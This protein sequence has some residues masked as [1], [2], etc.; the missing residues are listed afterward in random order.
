MGVYGHV[1]KSK[2]FR[3]I[4]DINGSAFY[5]KVSKQKKRLGEEENLACLD[6][7]DILAVS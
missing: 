2:F 7:R 5:L 1:Y 4:Y 6:N 3:K